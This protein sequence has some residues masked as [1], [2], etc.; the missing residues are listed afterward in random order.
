MEIT[1]KADILKMAGADFIEVEDT[2]ACE[3][4]HLIYVGG[5][6]HAELICSPSHLKDL[7]AGYLYTLGRE[8]APV[9][10]GLVFSLEDILSQADNFLS[11][12][13][14]FFET[15]AVHSCALVVDG[16]MM[17]FMED[18]GRHNAMDKTIGAALIAGT[19]LEK[20]VILTSG[21]VPSDVMKKIIRAG[22]QAIVSRSAPTDA[23]I[24][25]AKEYNVTLCGFARKSRMNVYAGRQRIIGGLDES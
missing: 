15:G 17:H 5:K 19:P 24:R 20:G 7:E 11:E 16:Q 25:L 2:V 23:A 9:P 6:L 12:S 8:L 4:T 22:I 18:I 13:K 10:D 14:V 3:Y 21:R 1:G